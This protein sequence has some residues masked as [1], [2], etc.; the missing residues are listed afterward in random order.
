MSNV[1]VNP[2]SPNLYFKTVS[3]AF[4][5]QGSKSG[6][7]HAAFP[8]GLPKA[9]EASVVF[10]TSAEHSSSDSDH[11]GMQLLLPNISHLFLAM[12][13]FH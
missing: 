3:S 1:S 13:I 9:L 6:F 7:E 4:C 11:G 5:F 12:L 10:Q 8:N 2:R